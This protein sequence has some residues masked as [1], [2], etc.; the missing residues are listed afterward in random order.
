MSTI[1][2]VTTYDLRFPTSATLSG[3]DAMNKDPDY[4]AAYVTIS[5]DADDG[6][7]GCGFVFTIGR[8]KTGMAERE[9]KKYMHHG[10]QR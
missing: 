10:T 1:T 6:L 3:S 9:A 4:S 8:G 2:A 5:T 7:T